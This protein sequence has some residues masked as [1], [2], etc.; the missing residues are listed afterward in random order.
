M[1]SYLPIFFLRYAWPDLPKDYKKKDDGARLKP[2][3]VAAAKKRPASETNRD[4]DDDVVAVDRKPSAE[5]QKASKKSPNLSDAAEKTKPRSPARA[6][7][8]SPARTPAATTANDD[9]DDDVYNAETDTEGDDDEN[10]DGMA[11]RLKLI[12]P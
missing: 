1:H 4:D 6:K 3:G 7:I 10:G 5:D 12:P 2:A 11:R 8:P 9:D